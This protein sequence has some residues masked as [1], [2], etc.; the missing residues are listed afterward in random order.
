MLKKLLIITVV[1]IFL[2]LGCSKKKEQP[3]PTGIQGT[4]RPQAGFNIDVNNTRVQIYSGYDNQT[5]FNGL[6]KE[7]AATGSS[8]EATYSIE[9]APG[10][11]YVVAW[12]DMDNDH[13]LSG[14]DIYGY[15]ANDL[16]QPLAVTVT[17]GKMVTV[18]FTVYTYGGGGASNTINGTAS[19]SQ[20]LT[21]DLSGAYASI[22]ASSNDW[23]AD[24]YISRIT[25]S[26]S[27]ATV[28]FT[29]N[30]VADGT[31]YLDIWKDMD[32]SGTWSSGDFA[33]VY[34]SLNPNT[35]NADLSPINVSGGQTQTVSVTVYRLGG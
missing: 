19:L 27:G 17:E 16:G 34:G 22:Y 28:N 12:K 20:G 33:G 25:V 14:G 9:I 10:N 3:S 21:G 8:V 30:D 23:A 11:Y 31:Y 24:N 4:I 32:G 29:F 6:V 1:G 26:G 18:D 7:D 13:N 5:G 15:Y 35:G 2:A